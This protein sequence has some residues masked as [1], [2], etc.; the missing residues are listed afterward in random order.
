MNTLQLDKLIDVHRL[1]SA[2][3]S[4]QALRLRA[5]QQR[6]QQLARA[7][8]TRPFYIKFR[9]AFAGVAGEVV[10]VYSD[11][12]TQPLIVVGAGAD[13]DASARIRVTEIASGEAW[14]VD[15]VPVRSL[16]GGSMLAADEPQPRPLETP[17]MLPPNEQLSIDV[18][19]QGGVAATEFCI[20]LS[21]VGVNPLGHQYSET[22][23]RL[24]EQ[25]I[26]ADEP[27][28]TV[29]LQMAVPFTGAGVDEEIKT[30]ET[31]KRD[32]PL[33]ICGMTMSEPYWRARI[34]D[35]QTNQ[36]WSGKY[37]PSWAFA[38]WATKETPILRFA[39]KIFLPPQ[40][41][42]RGEFINSLESPTAQ[43]ATVS[44]SKTVLTFICETP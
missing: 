2:N 11:P 19:N 34:L 25:M 38:G 14:S 6:M 35:V 1:P 30:A 18:V 29:F 42:L 8:N 17:H 5:Q 7:L 4:L 20:I 37:I 15:P 32:E 9:G 22:H 36:E 31:R 39:K 16:F 44:S 21:C 13:L 24:A 10:T 27:Q 43:L 28:Q 23:I 40:G 26:K 3:E 33:L 12:V 41:I